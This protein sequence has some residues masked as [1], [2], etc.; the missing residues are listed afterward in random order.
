MFFQFKKISD[1]LE[2]VKI[3]HPMKR[4]TCDVPSYGVS[5][6]LSFVKVGQ[7]VCVLDPVF[8]LCPFYSMLSCI[9]KGRFIKDNYLVQHF[10]LHRFSVSQNVDILVPVNTPVL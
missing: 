3:Q 7:P 1:P 10:F 4:G 9:V 2:R 6:H 8:C 5:D